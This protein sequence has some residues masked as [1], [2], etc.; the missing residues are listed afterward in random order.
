MKK[1]K[2]RLTAKEKLKITTM[3]QEI[4]DYFGEFY[5]TKN[6]LRLFLKENISLLFEGLNKGDKIIYESNKGIIVVTGFSDNYSRK[7]IK[8]LVKNNET[9]NDLLTMLSWN[10]KVDLWVKLKVRNPLFSVLIENG[11]EKF[12]SRG[13]EILLVRKYINK[14]K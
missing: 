5:I 13:K 14:E 2:S 8:F 3:I 7:Y 11:F 1:F 10:L 12:K 6:N 9:A 4:P